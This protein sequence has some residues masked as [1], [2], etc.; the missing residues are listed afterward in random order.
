MKD[1]ATIA[2]TL[3]DLLKFAACNLE[4]KRGCL[5]CKRL[6]LYVEKLCR[7]VTAVETCVSVRGE[8][9]IQF[10]LNLQYIKSSECG[11]Y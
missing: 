11:H 9:H 4:S 2:V 5:G 6:L 7:F 3:H 1:S 10:L 8:L